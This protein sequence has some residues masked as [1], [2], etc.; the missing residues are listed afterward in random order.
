MDII[1]QIH[2]AQEMIQ[3]YTHRLS[4]N[5]NRTRTINIL[6][7]FK[8]TEKTLLDQLKYLTSVLNA[9]DDELV[10]RKSVA[11]KTRTSYVPSN[12]HIRDENWFRENEGSDYNLIG[13]DD[14][15]YFLLP[16]HD[17]GSG[18]RRQRR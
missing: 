12:R 4:L 14:E 5:P 13:P 6:R 3:D 10:S 17:T 7:T 8:E 11:N 16:K 1:Q 9:N 15:Q 18:I 2:S